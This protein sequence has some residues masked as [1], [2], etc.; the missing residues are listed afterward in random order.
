MVLNLPISHIGRKQSF[1]D[2]A[3]TSMSALRSP[4]HVTRTLIAPTLTVLIAVLV[5]K[6][7][8]EMEYPVKV[9]T[10]ETIL[11]HHQFKTRKHPS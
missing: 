8:M 2:F 4:V 3:Q 5:N 6:G 7:S 11:E 9:L 10:C 1:L